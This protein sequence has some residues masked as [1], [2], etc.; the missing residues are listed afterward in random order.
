LNS[1]QR[2]KYVRLPVASLGRWHR[3]VD[4]S[5]PPPMDFVEEGEEVA[6]E[7]EDGYWVNARSTVILC[8]K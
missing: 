6:L 3:V 8:T 2:G 1:D 7:P 4:T 5:L